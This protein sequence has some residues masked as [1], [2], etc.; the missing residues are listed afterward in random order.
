MTPLVI[1]LGMHVSGFSIIRNAVLMGYPIVQSIRS[2][3]PIVDEFVIGVG[4]SDDQ[5]K[6][7]IASIQSPKIKV[8]DSFWDTKKTTGG[9]ILSEKTNEALARCQNDWCFYIQADEVVHEDDLPAIVRAMKEHENN[10]DVQGLLFK[11]VHFYGSYSVVATARNWYRNEVR[12]VKKNTGIQSVGDAQSFRVQGQKPRVKRAEARIFHY[13][14]VKPPKKMGQK[15]KLLDRWWH[16]SKRDGL[17]DQFEY[18]KS[19]GLRPYRGTHPKIMHSLVASQDWTFEAGL[20]VSHW[21]LKDWNYFASD[22]FE[23]VF[24]H[25]IGEYKSYRLLK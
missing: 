24:R 1:L 16:G 7:L 23:R 25:R 6:E 14:W 10:P 21:N 3:L 9:L 4:Q 12:I 20:P 15:A 5:T 19:Y 8:F 18:Q 13:G 22:M 2:I 17:Y 11:Y